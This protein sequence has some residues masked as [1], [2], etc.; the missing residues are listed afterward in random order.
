[1]GMPDPDDYK[2]HNSSEDED[3]SSP[4]VSKMEP[5]PQVAQTPVS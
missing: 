1:M 5:Q 2:S 4:N 3:R